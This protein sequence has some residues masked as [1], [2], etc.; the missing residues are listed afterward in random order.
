MRRLRRRPIGTPATGG[1]ALQKR[2]TVSTIDI[3]VPDI[4]TDEKVDVVEVLVAVGDE[5]AGDDGLVTLESDKASMDV[6]AETAGKVV[7]IKVKVGDKVGEGDVILVLEP[8]DEAA[9]NADEP[10]AETAE[11]TP[12][13]EAPAAAVP[14]PA[15]CRIVQRRPR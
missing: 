5:V 9:A 8:A 10:A 12:S 3:H 15:N 4:G 11:K 1:R 2:C 6:P 7:E 14:K 13:T